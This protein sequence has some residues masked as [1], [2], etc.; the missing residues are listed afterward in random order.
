[1]LVKF[2]EAVHAHGKLGKAFKNVTLHAPQVK[3][4]AISRRADFNLESLT[5]SAR[6]LEHRTPKQRFTA[7]PTQEDA[8][9]GR[10]SILA[11]HSTKPF[12]HLLIHV[13][14]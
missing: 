2:G 14:P 5:Q 7:E 13:L 6:D 8:F 4:R 10:S 11:Q 12:H 9:T 1:M 3:R